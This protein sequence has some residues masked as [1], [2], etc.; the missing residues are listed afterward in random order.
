[1]RLLDTLATAVP[2]KPFV[3]LE[4]HWP[5][6][7]TPLLKVEPGHM[8]TVRLGSSN[9]GLVPTV[10]AVDPARIHVV[11]YDLA[12]QPRQQVADLSAELGGAAVSSETN[13]PFFVRVVSSRTK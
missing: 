8:A 10:D 6:G 5:D 12:S 4:L 3:Q 13:P 2:A 11:V 7:P 1:M 9:W